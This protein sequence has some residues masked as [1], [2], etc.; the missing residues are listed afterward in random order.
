MSAGEPRFNPYFSSLFSTFEKEFSVPWVVFKRER[1]NEER[2]GRRVLNHGGQQ[3]N[4]R[5]NFNK[6]RVSI[7]TSASVM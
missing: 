2:G 4:K 7:S 1:W 6:S 5:Q 3:A